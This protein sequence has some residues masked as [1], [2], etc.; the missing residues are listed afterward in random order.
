MYYHDDFGKEFKTELHFHEYLDEIDG[1][2]QWFR[3]PA[4]KLRV[5]TMEEAPDT[6]ERAPGMPDILAD[7]KK[8]TGLLLQCPQGI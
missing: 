1:R 3:T 8:H 7:T 5:L 4:K 2:A 6:L